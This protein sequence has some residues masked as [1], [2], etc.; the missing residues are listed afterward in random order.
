[1][2]ET[3][4]EKLKKELPKIKWISVGTCS[5]CGKE[6]IRDAEVDVAVCPCKNQPVKVELTM[7][8]ILPVKLELFFKSIA[9]KHDCTINDVF[10]VAMSMGL[11]KV[12][13]M[14]IVEFLAKRSEV[15]QN[16]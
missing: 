7:A 2:N 4:T 13:K 9:D 3:Q 12:K 14:G 10:S 11:K 1:M 5:N 6:L 8:A 15:K 16:G